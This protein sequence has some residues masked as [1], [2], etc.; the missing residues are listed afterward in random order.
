M[1]I[2]IHIYIERFSL[3]STSLIERKKKIIIVFT[4]GCYHVAS[5][6]IQS[7][8]VNLKKTEELVTFCSFKWLTSYS[9]IVITI[10]NTWV[11]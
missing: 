9:V 5:P 3:G 10:P 2:I 4:T 11:L 7:V 6:S 1:V 8:E